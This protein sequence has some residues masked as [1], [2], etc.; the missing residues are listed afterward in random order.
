MDKVAVVTRAYLPKQDRASS[1]PQLQWLA[2]HGLKDVAFGSFTRPTLVCGKQTVESPRRR[3]AGGTVR[4][5]PKEEG[6][7]RGRPFP[8]L[9][10]NPTTVDSGTHR[11]FPT[12]SPNSRSD[13]RPRPHRGGVTSRN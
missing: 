11:P 12:F 3:E 8:E 2:V 6:I 5:L 13:E 10:D 7:Y 9:E 4:V 1:S